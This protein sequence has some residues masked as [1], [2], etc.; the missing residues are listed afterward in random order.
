MKHIKTDL[1]VK[2]A[3]RGHDRELIGGKRGS[4]RG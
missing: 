2:R 4:E 1:D 3:G